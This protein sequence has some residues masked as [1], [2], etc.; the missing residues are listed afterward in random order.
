M[1]SKPET[2]SQLRN[3]SLDRHS[4][5]LSRLRYL[6]VCAQMWSGNAA[7]PVNNADHFTE[8]NVVRA[9]I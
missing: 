6:A 2:F 1:H 7:F 8:G 5:T 4:S 3:S 9:Q